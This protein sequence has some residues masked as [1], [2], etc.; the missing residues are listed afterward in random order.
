ME[1]VFL[2]RCWGNARKEG[3]RIS[4]PRSAIASTSHLKNTFDFFSDKGVTI[5]TWCNGYGDFLQLD[6]KTMID[7]N[8]TGS[9]QN[10][11]C[12]SS[13]CKCKYVSISMSSSIQF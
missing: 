4:I 5:G 13:K 11:Y 2:S 3:S 6:Q 7:F 10:R 8:D 9:P 12:G 1:F